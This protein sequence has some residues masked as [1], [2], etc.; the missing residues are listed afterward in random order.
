MMPRFPGVACQVQ[1]FNGPIAIQAG[2]RPSELAQAFRGCRSALLVVGL[3]SGI[4]NLLGLTGSL[5]MLQVYD[6]VLPSHSVPTLVVLSIAMIGLY[7]FYGI[8][9]IVRL[10][11]L[12]RIGKRFDTRL[13]PS[14]F[15]LSLSLPLRSGPESSRLQPIND[16]DQIRTFIGS[17]GPTAFFDLPWLPFYVFGIYLL[18][19]W[20]GLLA[21]V[22]AVVSILLTFLAEMLSRAPARRAA[23]SAVA[24][25]LTAEA[26]RRN[27]EIIKALGL[28]NRIGEIWQRKSSSFLSDQLRITDTIGA[29]GAVSRTWRLILQS[30]MLGLGGYLAIIGEA[31]A[32]VII[33]SSIMLTRALSPVDIAI[34]NWRSFAAARQSYSRLNKLLARAPGDGRP[35]SLPRPK[36]VLLVE[37][38]GVGAPG[39]SKPIIQNVMFQL[40][41]GAGLGIIGPSASGKSTLARALVGAWMPMRGKVRLD[42]ASLDQFDPASLGRDIG[43]LPQDV[44]LFDGTVAD[45]ISRFAENA[46]SEAIIAAAEAA[47]VKDMILRLPEGFQTVVGDGGTALSAGQRQLV[48]LARAL[49]GDPFLVVLDEPNSNL[50]ADGDVALANATRRV[51]ERGGIAIVIAHRPSALTNLDQ[52]MVLAGGMIQAFG[53]KD[54]VLA[55]VTRPVAAPRM[56]TPKPHGPEEHDATVV[57]LHEHR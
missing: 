35:M 31:S 30:L 49:Y 1:N 17:T 9:D 57:P 24:R 46:E 12:V 8:L 52:I 33:A 41:A 37:N 18:H 56:G 45:N 5:Y 28:G 19:S 42:G 11:L 40:G 3:F 34:A 22:G 26:A 13:Q 55:K 7:L 48:G 27:A 44:E 53:P 50:D 47:G 38:L 2:S 21:T 51:R 15:S 10:R 20:L 39:Q 43:Y 4:L 16:L 14:V 54:E 36:A 6:R 23:E 32:G 25:R 29:T